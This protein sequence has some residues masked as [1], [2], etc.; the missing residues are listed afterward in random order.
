VS[1]ESGSNATVDAVPPHGPAYVWKHR[2]VT[3]AGIVVMVASGS[4]PFTPETGNQ[5]IAS[6]VPGPIVGAGLPGL[7]FASG[8]LLA[9]WR[10]K[11]SA[12]GEP[13]QSPTTRS[14]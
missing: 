3:G 10:R 5:D 4:D 2:N 7:I 9:L 8:G 12:D 6:A 14:R 13:M 11:R 1:S